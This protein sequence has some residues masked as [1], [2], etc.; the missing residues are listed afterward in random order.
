MLRARLYEAELAKREAATDAM[1]ASKT[2][3]GWG[4]QIRSYVLQPYQMVKD[5]RTGVEI[6]TPRRCSTATSTAFFGR[7]SAAH[8]GRR[9]DQGGI[10]LRRASPIRLNSSRERLASATGLSRCENWAEL[11]KRTASGETAMPFYE[12]GN[13][14]IRYEEVGSGFPLLVTPGGA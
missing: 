12:K 11:S 8:P 10:D 7:A 14:R 4:H 9:R 5:L 2:D 6:A 3:I 13:V 1:N